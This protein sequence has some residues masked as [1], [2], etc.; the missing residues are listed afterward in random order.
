MIPMLTPYSSSVRIG[1]LTP[2]V[3]DQKITMLSLA[4]E[5]KT[6]PKDILGLLSWELWM[7][8]GLI[9]L[10]ALLVMK[11]L[12]SNGSTNTIWDTLKTTI[13]STVKLISLQDFSP[14]IF[15]S[16]KILMASLLFSIFLLAAFSNSMISTDLVIEE[17]PFEIDK[18]ED[19]L[20]PRA[21]KFIPTWRKVG[22][23][24]ETFSK[25]SSPIKQ[26][27]WQK[28]QRIGLDEC[29]LDNDLTLIVNVAEEYS[30][31]PRIAFGYETL[32]SFLRIHTCGDLVPMT[33]K[34]V[35]I[36][37]GMI[38]RELLSFPYHLQNDTCKGFK[39]STI[40]FWA[41]A[42]FE[43]NFLNGPVWESLYL[44]T[45]KIHDNPFKRWRC[46]FNK[47]PFEHENWLQIETPN[48]RNLFLLLLGGMFL[49]FIV[50]L[51]E[52]ICSKCTRSLGTTG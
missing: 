42:I 16:S 18:L 29:L 21:S 47:D 45:F 28:A 49:S 25:S 17:K 24:H 3:T 11:I 41:R 1:K 52:I 23:L 4:P 2:I 10:T 33:G 26:K 38:G 14:K 15:G 51:S 39:Q 9:V 32:M 20:D 7:C 36:G 35:H 27:I 8:G 12:T 13:W 44:D 22:G 37:S 5:A 34:K 40:E 46:I 6:I 48:I 31:S 50:L 43:A 19:V 30:S